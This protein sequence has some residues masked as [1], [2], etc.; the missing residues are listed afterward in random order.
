MFAGFWPTHDSNQQKNNRR[1]KEDKRRASGISFLR[2]F[3]PDM[4]NEF[5]L[6]KSVATAHEIY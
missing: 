4:S 5:L 1:K 2:A 6:K 3:F